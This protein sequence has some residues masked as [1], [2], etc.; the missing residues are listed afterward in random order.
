[1]RREASTASSRTMLF[2][3]ERVMPGGCPVVVLIR[4]NQ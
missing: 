1:M 4:N 3:G 2:V